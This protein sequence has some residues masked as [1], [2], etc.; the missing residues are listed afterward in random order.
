[1]T[2]CEWCHANLNI[3]VTHT[4]ATC[5]AQASQYCVLC[6]CYGHVSDD[7]DEK[8][9]V[10]RPRTYEE[11]IPEDIRQRWGLTTTTAIVWRAPTLEDKEREIPD[12]A[13]VEVRYTKG[14]QD[15]AIRAV[16]REYSITTVHKMDENLR[17]LRTWAVTNGKKVRLIQEK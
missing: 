8:P 2:V 17:A 12:S 10:R 14:R 5:P 4:T 15:N 1:M 11:L 6:G 3:R 9:H 13:T 16:M 7:C